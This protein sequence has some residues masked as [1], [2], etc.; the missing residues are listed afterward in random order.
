[1]AIVNRNELFKCADVSMMEIQY[2]EVPHCMGEIRVYSQY[3]DR[4]EFT[5]EYINLAHRRRVIAEALNV[6][7]GLLEEGI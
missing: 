7:A 3:C 5:K 6:T 1:M 2:A 4:L